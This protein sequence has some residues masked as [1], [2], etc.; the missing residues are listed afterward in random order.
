MA[1]ETASWLKAIRRAGTFPTIV[2]H[3]YRLVSHCVLWNIP[4]RCLQIHAYQ[5]FLLL[6]PTASLKTLHSLQKI[7]TYTSPTAQIIQMLIMSNS[8]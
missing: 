3:H 4:A 2:S 5:T 8:T 1:E 7:N 6:Q